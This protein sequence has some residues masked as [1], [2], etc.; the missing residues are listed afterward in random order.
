MAKSKNKKL[1]KSLVLLCIG[2]LCIIVLFL[3]F[4]F[5]KANPAV[6]PRPEKQT[7]EFTENTAIS[8]KSLYKNP[9]I[10]SSLEFKQRQIDPNIKL[11]NSSNLTLQNNPPNYFS[12]SVRNELL[13]YKNSDLIPLKCM[14]EQVYINR[15]NIPY[16]FLS[17]D[18]VY[19][20]LDI[21]DPVILQLITRI[22]GEMPTGFTLSQFLACKTND[23]R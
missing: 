3:V 18:G 17:T 6:D 15:H 11:Y 2:L 8:I 23:N 21:I 22:Q 16:S 10:F 4:Y 7:S 13:S 19:T 5:F 1:V 12:S 9:D 20:K 14:P